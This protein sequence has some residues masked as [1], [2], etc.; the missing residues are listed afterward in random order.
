MLRARIDGGIRGHITNLA[1]IENRDK[2]TPQPVELTTCRRVPIEICC[3][4]RFARSM[5]PRHLPHALIPRRH[6]QIC[7]RNRFVRVP[8]R[9]AHLRSVL[10]PDGACPMIVCR[11]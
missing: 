1:A 8:C 9:I 2:C 4:R 10:P 6:A 5:F 7:A 11:P 3:S